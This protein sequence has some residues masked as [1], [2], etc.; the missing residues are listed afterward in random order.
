MTPSITELR[1]AR[2]ER[3]NARLR[4]LLFV[5]PLIALAPLLV[6]Y[7]PPNEKVE[8]SEFVVRDKGGA[9]RARIYLDEQGK[10]RL[11]LRD[12]D[13]KSTAML[14]S[15]EGASMSLGDRDDKSSVVIGAGSA[16]KGVIVLEHDGKPKTWLGPSLDIQDPWASPD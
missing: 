13:G 14:T 3:D 7:V 4:R 2:L 11:M 6:A 5:V 10:T 8:A 1:L 9:V 15:G 16:A 12:R